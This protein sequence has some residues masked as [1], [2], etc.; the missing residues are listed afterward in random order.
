MNNF[1][2]KR[3]QNV[4]RHKSS[5]TILIHHTIIIKQIENR[6]TFQENFTVSDSQ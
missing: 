5:K 2:K 4:T 6:L 1:D 3:E